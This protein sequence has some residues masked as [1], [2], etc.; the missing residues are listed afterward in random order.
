MPALIIQCGNPSDWIIPI[1]SFKA[2]LNISFLAGIKSV[3]AIEDFSL[4]DGDVAPGDTLPES[5]AVFPFLRHVLMPQMKV[6]TTCFRK[7]M[8]QLPNML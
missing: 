4:K 3:A 1:V 2:R 8:V 7:I 5:V 6:P